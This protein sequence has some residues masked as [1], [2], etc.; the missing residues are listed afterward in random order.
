MKK[1][2]LG[3]FFMLVLLGVQLSSGGTAEAGSGDNALTY[4]LKW[5]FN[6]SVVGD[7]NAREM[8]F[9]ARAGLDVT[10]RC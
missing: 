5:L 10:V 1:K 3:L 2:G 6:A 9:F 4:R 8:G 7:L